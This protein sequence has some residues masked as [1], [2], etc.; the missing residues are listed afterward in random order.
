MEAD[1]FTA[2]YKNSPAYVNGISEELFKI[3]LCLPSGPMVSDDDVQ[4]I[5]NSI[6]DNIL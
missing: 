2:V 1:A 6:K 4:F 3:G 5:I